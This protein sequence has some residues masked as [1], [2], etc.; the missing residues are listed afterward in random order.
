MKMYE[1]FNERESKG[2]TVLGIIL[3]VLLSCFF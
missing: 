3:L 2:W 1:P